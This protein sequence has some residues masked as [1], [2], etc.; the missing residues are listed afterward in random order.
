[1][2]NEKTEIMTVVLNCNT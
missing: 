1:M 2:Y